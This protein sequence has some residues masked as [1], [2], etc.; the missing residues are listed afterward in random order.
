MVIGLPLLAD[1]PPDPKEVQQRVADVTTQAEENVVGVRVVKAFAQEEHET[2][3]FRGGSER[4]FRQ[5]IGAAR[6][7]ARYVPAMSALPSLAIAGV[8]LVGGHQVIQGDLTL[9]DF[10]A[11][12]AYLLLLVMPLRMIGMWV[13]Q[14]Q[15]AM[16][17]GR[18]DLRGAGRGARHRRAAGRA[19]RCPTG[20][21]TSAS[22]TSRSAT[23]R[24]DRCCSTST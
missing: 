15:R 21:G 20:P 7:Q 18:A 9:G 8:L 1:Q 14:Y 23:R 4:I 10:F 12:N 3:R 11:V 22:R 19:P 13:G 24:A 5:G 16:A 2:T 17:V 6:L